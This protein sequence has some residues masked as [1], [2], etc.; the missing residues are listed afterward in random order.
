MCLEEVTYP[1]EELLAA[2]VVEAR[3]RRNDD[4]PT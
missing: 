4:S 3:A 1:A 2:R